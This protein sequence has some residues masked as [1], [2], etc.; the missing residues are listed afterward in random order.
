MPKVRG[1]VRVDNETLGKQDFTTRNDGKRR[2]WSRRY[3]RR[4]TGYCRF[5]RRAENGVGALK[6]WKGAFKTRLSP[7][8]FGLTR[9]GGKRRAWSRRSDGGTLATV[10]FDAGPRPASGRKGWKA[11]KTRLSPPIFGL[12][13]NNGKRRAWSRRYGRRNTGYCRF[14]RRA[15][16]GVGAQWLEGRLQN[17][18]VAA[19]FRFYR[20]DRRLQFRLRT[21]PAP[22]KRGR[23]SGRTRT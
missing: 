12:T 15:E 1:N 19:D 4:N 22:S 10:A 18:L 13:R 6:G 20:L 16:N 5:R 9:N 11:F 17:A 21:S 8:I 2:A 3:G 7:P 23:T 14:R